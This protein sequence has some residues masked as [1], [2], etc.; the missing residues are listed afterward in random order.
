[1]YGIVAT[2]IA[3]AMRRP[4]FLDFEFALLAGLLALSWI[5]ALFNWFG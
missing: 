5:A 2:A 1:L 3:T 4:N